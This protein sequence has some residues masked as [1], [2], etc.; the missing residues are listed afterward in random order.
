MRIQRD[1]TPWWNF[2]AWKSGM[3]ENREGMSIALSECPGTGYKLSQSQF[4]R[5]PVYCAVC[6]VY[7]DWSVVVVIWW[8]DALTDWPGLRSPSLSL[9]T[10]CHGTA[11]LAPLPPDSGQPSDARPG[12]S[13]KASSWATHTSKAPGLSLILSL[14]TS[15][16]LL[17][18]KI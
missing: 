1:G 15:G 12:P 18:S 16:Y 10:Q 13:E 17:Y 11:A 3:K 4:S 14:L 6:A 9:C 7:L 2:P 5:W 8:L